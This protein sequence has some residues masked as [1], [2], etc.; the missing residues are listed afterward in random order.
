M[1]IT[2]LGEDD[3]AGRIDM[4]T[5]IGVLESA[6]CDLAEGRAHNVPRQRARIPGAVLHQMSAGIGRLRV[7]GCKVYTTTR[8]GARFFV[9]LFD[10]HTAEPLA[11]LA[12]DRLGRLRTGAASGLAVHRLARPDATTVGLIG[13]GRQ[14]ETQLAAVAAVRPIE[15]AK[16][17]CRDAERRRAFAEN[18]RRQ[19]RLDVVPVDSPQAAVDGVPIV[20]TITNS[21]TPVVTDAALRRGSPSGDVL[22]CA[23]GSNWPQR[24]ELEV[25][26][27]ERCTTV[28]CDQIAACRIEAGELI[29]AA[30][31]G[32]FDWQRAIELADV[33]AGNIDVDRSAGPILFKS[34]GLA[35][36][37]VAVAAHVLRMPIDQFSTPHSGTTGAV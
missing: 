31:A 6:F 3:V 19:L 16:V 10:S 9:A 2:W 23:V 11:F 37:D 33:V 12:A 35:L 24:S 28:V 14:A 1:S 8:D 27:V 29:Q 25:A 18:M 5:A 15:T 21:K 26:T 36:E 7:L 17:F 4:P 22:I 20:V 30:K 13:C 32:R 34:V